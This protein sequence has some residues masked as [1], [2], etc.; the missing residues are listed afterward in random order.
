MHQH[1]ETF[2]VNH[3]FLL[4]TAVENLKEKS[5][6]CEQKLK[7][8]DFETKQL[9]ASNIV[10]KQDCERLKNQLENVREHLENKIEKSCEKSNEG[11]QKLKEKD[12]DI[13]QLKASNIVLKLDCESLKNQLENVRKHLETKIERNCER[14]NDRFKE[15]NE[16]QSQQSQKS[17][18]VKVD[19]DNLQTYAERSSKIHLT[20][21]KKLLR[22]NFHYGSTLFQENYDKDKD[23]TQ[24]NNMIKAV[25]EDDNECNNLKTLKD[26]INQ[27]KQTIY[28]ATYKERLENFCFLTPEGVFRGYFIRFGCASITKYICVKFFD[29]YTDFAK[30]VDDERRTCKV[31]NNYRTCSYHVGDCFHVVVWIAP[32]KVN[33]LH[34]SNE[35][36]KLHLPNGKEV[37][38]GDISNYRFNKQIV[39][40]LSPL[41]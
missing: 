13:K 15:I 23:V 21:S 12:L 30:E 28:S 29:K 9:K 37:N 27:Y 24:W 22:R 33:L 6:Q 26:S 11:E 32:H 4:L 1:C 31:Q 41:K 14:T 17:D 35:E 40:H 2:K 8:K 36:E 10:L 25:N 7:E 20:L 38:I 39:L 18:Q 34:K 3:E 16:K 5:N 19:I